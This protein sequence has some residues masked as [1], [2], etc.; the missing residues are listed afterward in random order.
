MRRTSVVGGSRIAAI[1]AALLLVAACGGGAGQSKQSGSSYQLVHAGYLTVATY[2]TGK[3]QVVVGPGDHFA[4]VDG[5]Y[6]TQFAKDHKLKIKLFQTTFASVIL[7]VQQRKADVGAY[8][9]YTPQRA[10]QMYYAYP[11]FNSGKTVIFTLKSFHYTGPSSMQGK[12]VGTVVGFVWAPYLQKWSAQGAAL[13]PDQASIGQALLNGQIQG[14]VNGDTAAEIP[15]LNNS[16]NVVQHQLKAGDYGL[17]AVLLTNDSYNIVNCNNKGLAT[18]LNQELSKL[19]SGGQLKKYY[20]AS[21]ASTANL[22]KLK[23]PP[24]GC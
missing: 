5:D 6:L 4:G 14:Y 8:I 12:K 16:S 10:K 3:P 21:G 20:D 1:L 24:Q 18:A 22:P 17:P 19:R 11:Y 23:S 2:G 7:A 15:P 9:F 13:Y